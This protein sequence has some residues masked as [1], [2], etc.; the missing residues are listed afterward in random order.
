MTPAAIVSKLWNF[1]HV[2]FA[3]LTCSAQASGGEI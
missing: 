2:L 3:C 1:C